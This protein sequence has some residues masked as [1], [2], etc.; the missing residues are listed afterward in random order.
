MVDDDKTAD[1][2]LGVGST[3]STFNTSLYGTGNDQ[4]FWDS[5]TANIKNLHAVVSGHGG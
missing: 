5:L 1:E 4:P 2:P 3:Q